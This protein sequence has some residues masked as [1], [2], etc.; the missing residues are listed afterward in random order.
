MRKPFADWV[1]KVGADAPTVDPTDVIAEAR[2]NKW[3]FS[4]SAEEATSITAEDVEIFI[5][6]V[7]EK[8]AEWLRQYGLEAGAMIFYCWHDD[9]AGQLR[10]SMVSASH[11]FLPFG[12][13]LEGVEELRVVVE[14][15]LRSPYLE[16]ISWEEL[17]EVP[18]NDPEDE[19]DEVEEYVLNIWLT[20]LP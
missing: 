4:L 18:W 20:A 8:R 12:C 1:E 6:A 10:F 15:W 16:G 3:M 7:T 5:D 17:E 2:D 19:E 11:G 14:E 13:Q 9:Q